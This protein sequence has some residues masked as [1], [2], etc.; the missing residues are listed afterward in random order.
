MANCNTEHSKK[1][2]MNTAHKWA[3]NNIKRKAITFYLD[4]LLDKKL[5]DYIQDKAKSESRNAFL[6]KV[7][8]LYMKNEHQED[9]INKNL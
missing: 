7:V 5:Y 8:R 9:K 6:K 3:K 1:L 4:Q 2:R